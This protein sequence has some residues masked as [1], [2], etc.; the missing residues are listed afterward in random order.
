MEVTET[1][2]LATGEFLD[3]SLRMVM[4]DTPA[5]MEAASFSL[6]STL[7]GEGRR[8][9]HLDLGAMKALDPKAGETSAHPNSN[10]T[11]SDVNAKIM[12]DGDCRDASL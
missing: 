7:I 1:A 3:E 10:N 5:F 11:T 4:D 8:H 2:D 9:N 12:G 6:P